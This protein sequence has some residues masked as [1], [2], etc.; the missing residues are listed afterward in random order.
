MYENLDSNW[1]K[2]VANCN[3]YTEGYAVYAQY[4][5]H[6]YLDDYNQTILEISKSNEL[7]SYCIIMLADIGI[8]YEGWKVKD[9]SS[10]LGSLGYNAAAGQE[11]YDLIIEMPTT[12]AAYGYGKL[13]FVQLHE[14]AKAL[15]GSH[16]NE[17][18]FNAMLLSRGWS[19]LGEL[20]NTYNEY[21]TAKCHKYGVEFSPR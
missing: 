18:E 2:A 7:A 5:A 10:Y 6:D 17:I 13:L 16:Y 15:L 20:E 8:H 21:M 3:A 12:Y 14:E 9:V 19:T 4:E 1:R 11:I